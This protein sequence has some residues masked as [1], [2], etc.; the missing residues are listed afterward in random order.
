M[1]KFKPTYIVRI[2]HIIRYQL[3]IDSLLEFG[4]DYSQIADLLAY[5]IQQQLV[6]DTEEGLKLSTAGIELLGKLNNEI[7]PSNPQDWILPSEEERISKI[8]KF[9]IYL[10]RKKKPVE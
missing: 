4:L 6:D 1:T 8:D 2:L 7:Y 3:S 9:E 10:P 5:V